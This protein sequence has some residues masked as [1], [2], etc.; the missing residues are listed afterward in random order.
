M[1]DGSTARLWRRFTLGWIP[2]KGGSDRLECLFRV[3]VLL[4]LLVAG[5]A[6]LAV[7]TASHLRLAAQ[8]EEQAQSRY[9]ATAVLLEAAPAQPVSPAIPWA[10]GVAAEWTT[11]AGTVRQG[12]IAAPVGADAG[13]PVT[14]WVDGD[15]DAVRAP[16]PRKAVV[17]EAV[18]TGG[19]TWLAVSGLAVA[20]YALLRWALD[21]YRLRRWAAGWAVVEPVWRRTVP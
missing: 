13:D 21:R 18:T 19:F 4:A 3:L 15:G 10:L 16:L 12:D 7:G 5:P 14:I 9:R 8:A 20:A 1:T 2:L 11:A 6:G 17:T